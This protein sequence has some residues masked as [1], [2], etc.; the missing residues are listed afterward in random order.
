MLLFVGAIVMASEDT[1]M[2]KQS[3]SGKGKDV[4]LDSCIET[5]HTWVSVGNI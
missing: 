5:G 4:K 2:F 1:T 3:T